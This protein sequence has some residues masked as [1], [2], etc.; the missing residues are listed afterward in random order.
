VN[1]HKRFERNEKSASFL[2]K[3]AKNFYRFWVGIGPGLDFQESAGADAL[4][5]FAAPAVMIMTTLSMSGLRR[6]TAAAARP[7]FSESPH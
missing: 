7:R 4:S 6:M 3:E 2:K 5:I 1:V